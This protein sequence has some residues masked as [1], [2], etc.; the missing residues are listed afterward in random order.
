MNAGELRR[1]LAKNGCTFEAHK[2]GSGPSHGPP[3]RSNVP[4]ADA[5]SEQRTRHRPRE[6]DFEGSRAEMSL[7]FPVILQADDNGTQLITCP[8]LPEV[9]SFAEGEA[10]WHERAQ[11]AVEEAIA[12]RIA[13]WA[14]VPVPNGKEL[15]DNGPSLT[16]RLVE[17]SLQTELKLMLF[18]S[19]RNAGIS[20]AELARRLSWHREQVD[21]LFR[22]DHAS[23]IDQI[24]AAMRAIGK[25][26]DVD[27]VD[28]QAA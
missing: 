25:T 12:A 9:T 10:D 14:D 4:V 13:A 2:G 6:Q 24:D 5:R 15:Y 26:F 17:L 16:H 21:R 23:R 28:S 18:R 8:V 3:R 20:R 19:C 27:V 1:F 11:D 22:I 7:L